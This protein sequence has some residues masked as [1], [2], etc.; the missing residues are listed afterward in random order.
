MTARWLKNALLKNALIVA[1]ALSVAPAALAYNPMTTGGKELRWTALPMKFNIHQA[2]AN[3]LSAAAT[4]AA[5][6]AAYKAWVDVSCSYYDASDQGVVNNEWGNENDGINTNTWVSGWPANMGNSALGVTQTIFDPYAGKIRDA[7]TLYNPNYKWGNDGDFYA[8]DAQSVATHEIGHQLGLDHTPISS[9]TMYF[10]SGQ[11]DTSPRSLHSDD[12]NGVCHLYPSGTTPPP[13]CTQPSDCSPMEDCVNN[14]CVAAGKKGYGSPCQSPEHCDTG[15]C[16]QS[17]GET[18]C[19]QQCD[20]QSCPN[21]DQCLSVS[22]G[23]G[24]I[25]KACL[26]NSGQQGTVKLG[27]P[28]QRDPDCISETC[29]SVPGKGYLCS[30]AC[31]LG[32][33]AACPDGY[34]CAPATS[35][36]LCIPDDEPQPSKKKLGE[37]CE[38]HA[39]CESAVCGQAEGGKVC[40]QLCKPDSDPCPT[41]FSCVSAGGDQHACVR[42]SGPAPGALGA[43]CEDHPDCDSK[44]CAKDSDGNGFCTELCE[45]DND[46]KKCPDSFTC[47]SAGGDKHACQPAKTP[48]PDKP[49]DDGGGGCALGAHDAPHRS[50][51][52]LALPLLGLWVLIRRRRRRERHS[53]IQRL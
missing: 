53:R 15:L 20:N 22:G 37:G 8:I 17:A 33:A 24:G 42:D 36:G 21:G 38:D 13:E 32:D 27:E 31:T 49:K 25:T 44:I 43:S 50:A 5:V 35:G 23:T 10:S 51:P 47:V 4:Q 48:P 18:F 40:T 9:A 52:W 7:D 28:C 41:G 46:D 1:W 12:I 19:S 14:K 30:Q 45:P 2:A 29:V 3:G 11:G 39:D 6:R 16:L 26:P 34:R